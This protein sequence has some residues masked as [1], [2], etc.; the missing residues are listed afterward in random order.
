M[1]DSDPGEPGAGRSVRAGTAE[2]RAVIRPPLRARAP[3]PL[4]ERRLVESPGRTVYANS[5]V[6]VLLPDSYAA[7]APGSPVTSSM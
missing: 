4:Y 7:R 6:C 3:E 2:P 1:D 5:S